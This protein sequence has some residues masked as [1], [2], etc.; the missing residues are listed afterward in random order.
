MTHYNSTHNGTIINM[1]NDG[2]LPFNESEHRFVMINKKSYE[3]F[4]HYSN[5]ILDENLFSRNMKQ[6][7]TTGEDAKY[8][9][10]HRNNLSYFQIFRIKKNILAKIIWC[11]WGE[12][13]L[14]PSSKVNKGIYN[15]FREVIGLLLRWKSNRKIKKIHA[16]G[17]GFEYDAI[18]VRQKFGDIKILRTEYGYK[19]GRLSVIDS[20][21]KFVNKE[22]ESSPYKIMIGHSAYPHL[23][24]IK[25]LDLLE[26]FKNENIIISLVL[27]YGDECYATKVE[28]HAKE[29][30]NDKVEIIKEYMDFKAYLDYL[31]SVDVWIFDYLGQNALGNFY[32]LL[33][34][35][36]KIFL[37]NNSLLML[38]ARL[39]DLEVYNIDN[40]DNMDFSEFIAM[41][42][43]IRNNRRFSSFYLN[44]ENAIRSWENT[45]KELD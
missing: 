36:K 15:K 25:I 35:E 23:N 43:N 42:S 20:A 7:N 4:Q 33:Y 3:D 19:K 34:L 37:N 29:L 2:T 24:H 45:F 41:N 17:I 40:I 18:A 6:F 12:D 14:Y 13:H 31:N 5:V 21:S 16:I 30:F 39:E 26:K 28:N 11:V 32:I 1:I 8:I 9:F 44:E 38:A 22:K 10:L 27:S